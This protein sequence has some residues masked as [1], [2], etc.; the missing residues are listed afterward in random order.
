MNLAQN[1]RKIMIVGKAGFVRS[2]P[3]VH[4]ERP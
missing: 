1:S 4:E 2:F 3:L